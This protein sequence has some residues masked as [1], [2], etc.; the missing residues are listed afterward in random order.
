[1]SEFAEAMDEVRRI[2]F[3]SFGI[4]PHLLRTPTWVP[5]APPLPVMDRHPVI[6]L[7]RTA[8]RRMPDDVLTY[9][10]LADALEE[11]GRIVEAARYRRG[12]PSLHDVIHLFADYERRHGAWGALHVVLDD[13]NHE[14][15]SVRFCV[16]TAT[17]K[18]D[19]EGC[20]LGLLLLRMS[21]SQ[22]GR[23]GNRIWEMDGRRSRPSKA[24]HIEFQER[25]RER[26]RTARPDP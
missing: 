7:L 19:Q 3:S 12:K 10:A 17:A 16:D 22:R 21:E 2:I 18:G 11:E 25:L 24:Q 13:N 26:R 1:M 5:T 14:D 20:Y 23:I 4:P 15:S 6:A 8:L 9:Q